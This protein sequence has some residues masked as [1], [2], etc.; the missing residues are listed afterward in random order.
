MT[1]TSKSMRTWFVLIAL[2]A[3]A[4]ALIAIAYSDAAERRRGR[5]QTLA[6]SLRLT[7]LA[8]SRLTGAIDGPRRLLATIAHLPQ[9]SADD[10]KECRELLPA[11]LADHAGYLNITVSNADG[12]LFCSGAPP[13]SPH[14]S[15]RGRAAFERALATK[16]P[17]VGDY[18]V[19]ATVGV[20]SVVVAQ[21]MLDSA[22]AVTRVLAVV[23]GLDEFDRIVEAV[24]LPPGASLTLFDRTG[25][26]LARRPYG[27]AWTGK[28]VPDAWFES[29][30]HAGRKEATAEAIGVDGV[31]RLYVT[32]PVDASEGT[33]L[34]VGMGVDRATAFADANRSL[35]HLLWLL[36]LLSAVAIA[37]AIGASAVF[38]SRP[39]RTLIE[40]TRELAT[41]DFAARARLA[42]TGGLSELALGVNAMAEA[43]ESRQQE[44]D[45]AEREL[46]QSEDRYRLIFERN[47]HPMWVFD[48]ETLAFL[49]VNAAAVQ[50]YGYTRDEFLAMRVTAVRPAEDVDIFLSQ[51]AMP[52]S[53][54]CRS[55]RWRH[56]A[57]SGAII[58]VD[59]T[60]FRFLFSGRAASHV[61][62][63]DVTDRTRAD[64]AIADRSR[65]NALLADVG[66]ALN[67]PTPLG[68]CLQ[69]TV[70]ALI[71]RLGV[72]V[73]RVWATNAAD[74]D[75]RLLASA[76]KDVDLDTP[77]TRVPFGCIGRVARE[78]S[79]AYSID[80]AMGSRVP[81]AFAGHP[82]VVCGR[83]AGVLA[84]WG[85]QPVSDAG[86]VALGAVA[87]HIALAITRDQSDRARGHLAS[88]V[89]A[90]EDAIISKTLDGIIVSWNGGA[91]NL[92]GYTSEEAIGQPASIIVP[93]DRAE[94]LSDLPKQLSDGTHVRHYETVRRRKDGAEVHVSMTLSAIRDE[95]GRVTR[96]SAIARD[97][98]S[99]LAA[100]RALHDAEER[101]R[102]ALEASDVG[103]WDIDFRSGVVRWSA[104]LEAQ[105]GLAPGTFGGTFD[106]FAAT[107]HLDER[108]RVI[109][110][111]DLALRERVDANLLY[112][113]VWPDGSTHWVRSAGRFTYDGA[114]APIRGA[115]ISTD[116]T[117]RQ[118]L[119]EQCRQSQKMEAIGQLAGGIAHDFNN[120][121]TAILGNAEFLADALPDQGSL[122]NDV[123]EIQHAAHR[124]AALTH[125]LLA[126]GRKQML[127]PSVLH[128]GDVVGGVTPMLR[129]LIGETIDLRTIANDHGR[130]KADSGQLE[131]V[132]VNLV[133]NARDAMRD[134]GM[135]TIETSDAVLDDTY[136]RR[137]PA[138]CSGP[139]V[140]IAVSDTGHGMDSAT[141]GRVFEPFFTTKPQGQGTGLGLSTVYGI[142]QQSGGS[143]WVYSEVGHGTTFKVYLPQTTEVAEIPCAPT[144][145][146]RPRGTE[147]ILVVEDEQVIGQL[148]EKT[149]SRD[150]YAVRTMASPLDALKY[151]AGNHLPINL[152]LTDV[153]LPDKCGPE[154]AREMHRLH[155]ETKVLF[156]SGYTEHA[157]VEQGMFEHGSRFL[158]KPFSSDTLTRKIREVLDGP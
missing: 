148:V 15:M 60:A 36:G 55:G 8:A 82:I 24:E 110:A 67:R 4:P 63:H 118:T 106:A 39:A 38:V 13:I 102:F 32:V 124:A 66:A 125:Q 20:P 158:P 147:S 23:I 139:H 25:T 75:L 53:S 28:Q 127:A 104:I 94:E 42:P 132:L 45:R 76:S 49:E 46:R 85:R 40:V 51:T 157:M 3:V 99:R 116:V 122:R 154:L 1:L 145:R 129:R 135:L 114:G 136:V 74:E 111:F 144:K 117:E 83:A 37:L 43:L 78:G 123:E 64:L 21:P 2:V 88:I 86:R 12:S 65:V 126:F 130:V 79:P 112:R 105:H 115:G 107:V 96:L 93:S 56:Q 90:S 26:I 108:Q 120:M 5:E 22:G 91:E 29:T 155:P 7:R 128:V 95:S 131:Q 11:I 14:V 149:L 70:D 57:K 152:L 17:T 113:T 69:A 109:E 156:M 9:M 81:V 35:R 10:P 89:E 143:I 52:P 142:V 50:L 62:I 87:D 138:A 44:R 6:D 31:S 34:Y 103:I 133:V 146:S 92:Y 61:T 153:I 77:E 16:K 30:L 134:G 73:A 71:E 121:L 150:G 33:G 18:Q 48:A 84:V 68:E 101:M 72:G 140:M 141:R 59:V 151:A 98:T 54:D 19:S 119:E 137:H 58:D 80:V 97:I 100:E 41:G 27:P 47:P